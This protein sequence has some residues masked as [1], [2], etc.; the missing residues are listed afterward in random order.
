MG[1]QVNFY[2]SES[3][4]NNFIKFL[5]QNKFIFLNNNASVISQV[6]LN[7]SRGVYLYK[8][9]YGDI[10][11]RENNKE[12]I[13][14]MY[15]PVIEFTKTIINEKEKKILRGR[16]WISQQYYDNTGKLLKKDKLFVDDYQK[17][18]RWIKK[19]VPYQGIMKGDYIVKEY[20]CNELVELVDR[21]YIFS[22]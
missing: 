4:Q 8:E 18:S 16:I 13:D 15:S 19:F 21:G 1:K 2:M 11:M 10:K 12:I 7:N 14:V 9:V 17:L 6:N 3:V 5:E 22:A 20:T